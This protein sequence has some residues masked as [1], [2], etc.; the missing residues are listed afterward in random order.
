MAE[1]PREGSLKTILE[2]VNPKC[3]ETDTVIV[4]TA[5]DPSGSPEP[6]PQGRSAQSPLDRFRD[7]LEVERNYSEHTVRAY[8]ADVREFLEHLER[9]G[10]SVEKVRTVD[11]RRF[12]A[13]RV[14]VRFRARHPD[15]RAVTGIT[16]GR[17]LSGRSQARKLSA[18][19]TFFALL[20]RRDW[21]AENPAAGLPA[22]RFFRPLPGRLPV[23]E[24]EDVLDTAA[25]DPRPAGKRD[26]A[27]YEMLYSSGMRIAELM[28]LRVADIQGDPGRVKV[29]GKG[30]K[31]RIVFLGQAAQTALREY[32]AVRARFRP[33][34]DLLFCNA[35]G[36][37]LTARGVR[38]RMRQL[39][40]SMGLGKRLHPHKFRHTFATD[41][42]NAG[43]DIRAVQ[44]LLGHSRPS[45]TQ[46]YTQVT[47]ERLREI[48]RQ[49]HPHARTD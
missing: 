19:R 24:L 23:G 9:E 39:E 18:V 28:N 15:P 44:E 36:G 45:T 16:T 25:A 5:V 27:V 10:L 20:R 37:P 35:R 41:L 17:K 40:R 6:D 38:Y 2:V 31:E 12:F 34:T 14:G 7:Y 3:S 46:I 30:G 48:Y 13:D 4:A 8:L 49:A 11:V 43:A 47:K 22:P 1:G 29:L 26:L 32:L 42:L 33:E 21:I